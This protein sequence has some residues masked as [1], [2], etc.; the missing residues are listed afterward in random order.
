MAIVEVQM[1][2]GFEANQE[3]LDKVLKMFSYDISYCISKFIW[4]C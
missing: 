4:K 2:S 1:V 3:S